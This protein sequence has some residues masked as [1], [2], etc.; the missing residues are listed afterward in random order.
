[1]QVAGFWYEER[2]KKGMHIHI[3]YRC[4][5]EQHDTLQRK[6]VTNFVME[7]FILKYGVFLR[8]LVSCYLED[9]K[10]TCLRVK[11]SS[12]NII[13]GLREDQ[14]DKYL[15]N[16]QFAQLTSFIDFNMLSINS[17]TLFYWLFSSVIHSIQVKLSPSNLFAVEERTVATQTKNKLT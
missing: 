4:K 12:K 13:Q 16:R 6:G 7:M 10:S 15:L 9:G 14:A 2:A 11:L 8:I 1:M 3:L 17:T 5:V